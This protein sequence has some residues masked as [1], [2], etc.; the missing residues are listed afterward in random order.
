MDAG[1]QLPVRR[2]H[3]GLRRPSAVPRQRPRGHPARAAVQ[4][5]AGGVG[6][7]ARLPRARAVPRVLEDRRALPDRRDERGTD[8]VR[9]PGAAPGRRR[10][11]QPAVSDGGRLAAARRG[12]RRLPSPHRGHP[13]RGL[14]ADRGDLR[15]RANLPRRTAAGLGRATPALPADAGGAGRPRTARGKTSPPARPVCWRS[16]ARPSS[17]ATS[18]AA[19]R[20]AT[21]ST[22]SASCTRAG[23]TPATSPASTRT[24]SS[25]S[26]AAPRT[27]SSAA[28]TTSTPPSSRTRCWPT[29]RSPRPARSAARTCTP[30]RYPSPT[31]PSPPAPR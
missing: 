31:S 23:W 22:A 12:P 10:H 2:R 27:S 18:P 14:R 13:D 16:A 21:C 3:G 7:A 15:Q 28:G 17:P 24:A 6:R 4:G 11:Q 5:A 29:R 8:R 9:R 26:P 20:T 1:R 25:T 19:T 30:A